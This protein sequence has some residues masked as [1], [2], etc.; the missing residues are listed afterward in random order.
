MSCPGVQVGETLNVIQDSLTGPASTGL[1][2]VTSS[3]QLSSVSDAGN[4]VLVK[5]TLT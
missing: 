1:G 4:I 3:W 2:M 5:E